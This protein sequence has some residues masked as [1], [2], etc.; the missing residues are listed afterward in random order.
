MF[1][2]VYNCINFNSTLR[3]TVPLS[4]VSFPNLINI[5]YSSRVVIKVLIS[6]GYSKLLT[7]SF[8]VNDI[9]KITFSHLFSANVLYSPVI[10]FIR[11][12]F[13]CSNSQKTFLKNAGLDSVLS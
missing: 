12:V 7:E 3:V 4:L 1:S 2:I 6:Y 10:N 8:S 5:L 11:T 9:F 13:L